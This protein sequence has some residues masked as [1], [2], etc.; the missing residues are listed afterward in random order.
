M[1]KV[2]TKAHPYM[3]SSAGNA[4]SDMLGALDIKDVGEIF[5]QIPETHRR[6]S[7]LKLPEQLASELDLK[8]HLLSVL[9]Q[10]GNCEDN[11][12]FLGAGCWQ[13][14]V[15]SICDEIVGRAEFL[16]NVWGTPSSDH[17][18]NQ[19]LF[20]FCSQLG[21]LLKLD[22]VGLPVYSYGCA[23]G[24]AIRL[25][26][27]ITGRKKVLIPRVIDPERKAVVVNYCAPEN[28]DD[29]I[30]IVEINSVAASGGIDLEHL[31]KELS[32]DVAAI[33]FEVP[34]YF[35]L[36]EQHG[37]IISELARKNGAKTIVGCDPISLGI[38]RSPVDYG[39]D[40]IVGP[41]QPLGVHMNCGGGVS[42]Y[43]ATPDEEVYVREYNTL[44]ISITETEVKGQYGFGLSCAG[45]TSYGLR[46]AGKDWTGNSTY[47]WAISGAVYMALMGPSGFR[48]IGELITQ[49]SNYAAQLMSEIEGIKMN[50]DAV[51]FKE[52]VLNF[53]DT[54]FSVRDINARLRERNIF[55][56]KDLS[57]E[58]PEL[59]QSA[60]YC[61]TEIHTQ[62]DIE[63]L[64]TSLK[65]VLSS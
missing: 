27:R 4:R 20:E 45:Q 8:R 12:N 9:S 6:K 64:A 19:A 51:V 46:E 15:P 53:D 63:R 3:P 57:L 21:D 25:A 17:G 38:L 11:L 55:G 37:Q 10:N 40:I 39:A 2:G 16:T 42:G 54:G 23:S 33:Y 58:F 59:G 61:V 62:K 50:F 26:S 65:E 24:H 28:M 1:D 30:E 7:P 29:H 36:I 22:M 60:L 14:H 41:V 43:I 52:F 5:E 32:D 48:E 31:E 18:R 56:G 47:L 44:N 13:H 49:Q 34:N 35:G